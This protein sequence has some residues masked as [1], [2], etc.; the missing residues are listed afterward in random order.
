MKTLVS[1]VK[2]IIPGHDPKVFSIF[3]AV[4]EGVAKIK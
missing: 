3:P 1:D 4:K 2:Y